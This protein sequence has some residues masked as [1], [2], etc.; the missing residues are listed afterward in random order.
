[1]TILL[2][3]YFIILIWSPQHGLWLILKNKRFITFFSFYL[4][5]V[6]GYSLLK[7]KKT[8]LIVLIGL[9]SFVSLVNSLQWLKTYYRFSGQS[10]VLP[11][12]DWFVTQPD[13]RQA[14]FYATYFKSEKL[15]GHEKYHGINFAASQVPFE[16]QRRLGR[17]SNTAVCLQEYTSYIQDHQVKYLI[18]EDRYE[19][20]TFNQLSQLGKIIYDDHI[21]IIKL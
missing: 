20:S 8:V 18:L 9:F 15:A 14:L 7:L 11:A 12:M 10:P 21:R 13:Y 1:M 6:L 19:L 16:D 17:C 3:T 5:I 4:F 2:A